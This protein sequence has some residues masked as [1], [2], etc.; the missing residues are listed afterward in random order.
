LVESAKNLGKECEWRASAGSFSA[1]GEHGDEHSPLLAA[2]RP[3]SA[4]GRKPDA[5]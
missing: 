4:G 5:E 3:G 2:G 1:H